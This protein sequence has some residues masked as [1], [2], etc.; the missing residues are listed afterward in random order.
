[1]I[2]HIA[3]AEYLPVLLDATTMT[4]YG[5]DEETGGEFFTGYDS[6]CDATPF[7]EFATAAYRFGHS[8]IHYRVHYKPPGGT[9]IKIP[10]IHNWYNTQIM[11]NDPE[12]PP[13]IIKGL[14]D[15]GMQRRDK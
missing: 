12:A 15:Q 6:S 2:Q 3:Y 9:S 1:M 14:I 8:T 4:Q 7:T 11:K 10:M 13:L 5:L